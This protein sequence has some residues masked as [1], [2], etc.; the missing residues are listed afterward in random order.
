M[1]KS[2]VIHSHRS[3]QTPDLL[4][5]QIVSCNGCSVALSVS[6]SGDFGIVRGQ[7]ALGVGPATLAR[8]WSKVN[9]DG[10]TPTSDPA[11]GPCW[12]WTASTIRGYGQFTLERDLYGKQPH[13]YAHRFAYELSFGRIGD[14]AIKACHR[15]DH[16]VCV[17]PSHLF[18][19]T[20]PDNLD[21]AR[22]KGRLVDGAHLIKLSDSDMDTIRCEY[23][24]RRNGKQ[25][26]ARFG[27]SLMT[28]LRVVNGTQRVQRRHGPPPAPVADLSLR[29]V[30]RVP[31]V[32][33]PVLGEVR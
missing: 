10:P 33:L 19:G 16:C 20:Q 30:V 3:E 23:V 25:L 27:V 12:T 22:R 11:L 5:K 1:S 17:R 4:D 9:P 24:P 18:L 7:D 2:D 21:D 13:V 8:F 31:V 6:E 26:A 29:N 15:C 32:Y 14:P 28:I